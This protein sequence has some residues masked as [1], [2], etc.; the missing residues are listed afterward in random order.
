MNL[1]TFKADNDLDRKITECYVGAEVKFYWGAESKIA[2]LIGNS[3][4][5]G[6]VVQI[7][8]DMTAF[9]DEITIDLDKNQPCIY[10]CMKHSF[11]VKVEWVDESGNYVNYIYDFSNTNDCKEFFD[12]QPYVETIKSI[13]I[14]DLDNMEGVEI[15]EDEE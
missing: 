15:D 1:R 7:K 3:I 6:F 2:P 8:E 9:I 4:N 11:M 12:E 14:L 5:G 13:K 10:Q